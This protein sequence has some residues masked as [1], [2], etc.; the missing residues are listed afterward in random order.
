VPVFV[1]ENVAIVTVFDLHE[2]AYNRV[3]LHGMGEKHIHGPV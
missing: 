1:Q 3:G 2:E